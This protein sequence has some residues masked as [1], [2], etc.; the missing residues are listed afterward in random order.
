[1]TCFKITYN[2]YQEQLSI[3]INDVPISPY[4][5]LKKLELLPFFQWA[6]NV[7]DIM[8]QEMNDSYEVEYCG[9]LAEYEILKYYADLHEDC[10][11]ITHL[12]LPLPDTPQKRLN[13]LERLVR[14]GSLGTLPRKNTFL[15]IC[16]ENIGFD[17]VYPKLSFN[18]IRERQLSFDEMLEMNIP[19]ENILLLHE[20]QFTDAV[21][22]KIKGSD[23]SIFCV[24]FSSVLKCLFADKEKICVS[25][26]KQDPIYG[27]TQILNLRV[28]P[29]MLREALGCIDYKA[30]KREFDDLQILDKVEP[31]VKVNIPR[32]VDVGRQGEITVSSIP[33]GYA[34]PKVIY[35]YSDSSLIHIDGNTIHALEEGVVYVTAVNAE[36]GAKISTPK[37]VTCLKR[38]YLEKIT[39]D[40]KKI[41]LRTG[42]TFKLRL[43]YIP[44]DADNISNI[45][46]QSS[47][48]LVAYAEN[49]II[50]TKY[51]GECEI[52]ISCENIYAFC[53]VEVKAPLTSFDVSPIEM[54]IKKGDVTHFRITQ[55]PANSL[56]EKYVSRAYPE[57]IVDIDI[58]GRMLHGISA[59]TAFVQIKTDDGKLSKNMRVTVIDT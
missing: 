9:Q 7:F 59:G 56:P 41:I 4:S 40:Q 28:Y 26:P 33:A 39:L 2:P 19:G 10:K 1:M 48:P 11:K 21:L 34:I 30:L 13:T 37:P 32:M 17:R 50:Y 46:Y 42:E 29:G 58:N 16:A 23:K 38:I 36:T 44:S 5:L 45:K 49:G 27:Y 6:A 12:D 24:V 3:Q 25:V 8:D 55:C 22:E 57:G 20:Y 18:R 52:T 35:E 14:N 51:D 43:T 47:D 15:N 31:C 54:Q 53:H